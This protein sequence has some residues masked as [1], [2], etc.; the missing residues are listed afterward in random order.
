MSEEEKVQEISVYLDE[1]RKKGAE[2]FIVTAS[3]QE[4]EGFDIARLPVRFPVTRDEI[5][6]LLQVEDEK[7]RPKITP[8]GQFYFLP[9][10]AEFVSL[11]KIVGGP[12]RT[13]PP[14]W[15]VDNPGEERPNRGADR[16]F[17]LV[18]K[19]K[20]GEKF[21]PNSPI[22]LEKYGDEYYIGADGR[23][24]IAAL[25]AMGVAE[26]PFIVSEAKI[27]PE[28]AERS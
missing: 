14:T 3:G 11:D 18:Q 6:T 19:F 5:I 2:A 13:D 22:Y 21:D 20:N 10:K 12:Y 25:K 16:I 28:S 8:R 7:N 1:C 9:Q 15:L 24:R 4:K 27:V 23:H 26:L 17:E